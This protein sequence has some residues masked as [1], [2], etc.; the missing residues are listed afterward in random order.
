MNQ[1]FQRGLFATP[2]LLIRAASLL[3]AASPVQ[4]SAF[5]LLA[6]RERGAPYYI[7]KEVVDKERL[8]PGVCYNIFFLAETLYIPGDI[9]RTNTNTDF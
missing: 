1:R 4:D 5:F 3:L 8:I 9:T 6:Q 7:T 2:L